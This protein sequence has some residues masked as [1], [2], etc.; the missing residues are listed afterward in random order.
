MTGIMSERKARAQARVRLT[1]TIPLP[2]A[3]G[4]DCPIGQ[5]WDQAAEEARTEVER[6]LN[7]AAKGITVK[8]EKVTAILFE[9]EPR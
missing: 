1:V 8:I 4:A 9:E 2:T 6:E 5:V 7:A 3:W